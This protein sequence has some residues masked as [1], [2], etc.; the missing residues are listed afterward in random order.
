MKDI[1]TKLDNPAIAE[2]VLNVILDN[3]MF[4]R[5]NNQIDDVLRILD[6]YSEGVNINNHGVGSVLRIIGVHDLETLNKLL[7]CFNDETA[8]RYD[9]RDPASVARNILSEWKQIIRN[10]NESKD[11]TT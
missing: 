6:P 2:A 9:K 11:Q 4:C 7:D 10:S 5:L 1:I 3:I 8:D